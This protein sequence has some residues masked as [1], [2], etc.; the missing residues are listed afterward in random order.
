MLLS[1][2]SDVLVELNRKAGAVVSGVG[3]LQKTMR[4]WSKINAKLHPSTRRQT[5]DVCRS[6]VSSPHSAV[7]NFPSTRLRLS[8][9]GESTALQKIVSPQ[10]RQ[11]AASLCN[12]NLEI[13]SVPL[14]LGR[15]ARMQ[16]V[17][18]TVTYTSHVAWFVCARH[19]GELCKQL[20]QSKCRL[21]DRFACAC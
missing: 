6:K 14:L 5:D 17:D 3:R 18:A 10:Y 11:K 4:R 15:I 21:G 1:Y 8:C 13:I 9:H 20:N 16:C 2:S 19:T 7:A 12:V